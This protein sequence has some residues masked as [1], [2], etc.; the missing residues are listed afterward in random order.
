[1]ARKKEKQ[2][3]VLRGAFSEAPIIEAEERI[4]L[5][6]N[7]QTT[8]AIK[9][10]RE[11]KNNIEP[12]DTISV[13]SSK[14]T[15]LSARFNP[16]TGVVDVVPIEGV[17]GAFGESDVSV[18]VTLAD[19]TVLPSQVAR[20]QVVHPDV[21]AVVLEPGEIVEKTIIIEV[22]ALNP[23]PHVVPVEDHPKPKTT[24]L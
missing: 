5:L 11:G 21:D 16:E 7:Q 20:Y 22:P 10:D 6:G 19:G 13:K 3:L 12:C 23:E 14:G 18:A 24:G 2:R 4:V 1:M 15:V 17:L 9:L 8:I